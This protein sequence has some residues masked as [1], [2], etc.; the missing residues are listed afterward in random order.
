MTIVADPCHLIVTMT[1]IPSK[2]AL[3]PNLQRK[4]C[5]LLLSKKDTFQLG[6]KIGRDQ[7]SLCSRTLL[8]N[9]FKLGMASHKG[10]SQLFQH[11]STR[12]SRDLAEEPL[13]W[14]VPGHAHC[15]VEL[16]DQVVQG[17]FD[18][19]CTGHF[20]ILHVDLDGARDGDVS[21]LDQAGRWDSAGA[22]K[23]SMAL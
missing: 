22:K 2:E 3:L 14:A 20:H 6:A 16:V 9:L 4:V 7:G 13:R 11:E 21:A 18:A 10:W 17:L 5:A 19:L 15:V 8:K 1:L 12:K 23:C